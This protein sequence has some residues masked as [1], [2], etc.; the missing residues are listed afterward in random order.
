MPQE[1]L[2]LFD[3]E[4]DTSAGNFISPAIPYYLD[5]FQLH[6]QSK[7]SYISSIQA[8]LFYLIIANFMLTLLRNSCS[9]ASNIDNTP[10]GSYSSV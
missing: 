2:S 4:N 5:T 1:I 6:T 10:A 9:F 8:T 3:F 7:V